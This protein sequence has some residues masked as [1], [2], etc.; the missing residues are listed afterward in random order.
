MALAVVGGAYA[1][2]GFKCQWGLGLG[3][4]WLEKALGHRA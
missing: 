1:G 4:T 3:P 2:V